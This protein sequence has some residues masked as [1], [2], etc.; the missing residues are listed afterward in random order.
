MALLD[1]AVKK[2]LTAEVAE[3]IEAFDEVVAHDV[4]QAEQLLAQL[5][6][7]AREA[8]VPF[9]G[10]TVTP[11]QNTIPKHDELP[12]PG[13]RALEERIESLIRWNAMAMVHKQNKYDAG[14]GGHIST[15]ASQATLLE[16]GFNHF[17]RASYGSQP[18]DFVYF[19]GHASPGVYSRAFLEGR[20]SEQHLKNFRHELRD[21]PG[22]SSYPHP[23]LMKDFWQFPTVSMGIGPLNAIYQA[24]FMRYLENRGLIEKTDRKIWAFVGD[25]ET[26]E[27]DT[28]GAISLGVREKLD[29]LIFVVNCNLQ[30][31]DGPVR[32]NARIIDELEGD[33]RGTGWNVIKVIWGSDWD[34]LFARDH[35]GLL[36]KRMEECVDGELQA[37]KAKGGAYLRENFFGKYPELLKLVE[38]KTDDQLA[39]L[40]RGGH[41]PLKIFNA[42]KQA[43]EHKGGPTVILAMTVKGYGMAFAQARNPTHSEKKLS[44]KDLEAFAK[45]FDA[46][47][48][49]EQISGAEF[50][51][52]GEKDPALAYMHARR[53]QL[54]GYLPK[55]E[56]K[57]FSFTA[58]KLDFFKEWLNGSKG[59]AASTTMGFVNML[60]G[61]LKPAS[62][63]NKY[64]V[65]IIPDEGRTFGFESVMKSVGIY[66]PEGQKYTPHDA[67]V[68][69]S[70]SEKKDGAILEE[71]ITEAGS[72]AS[73]TAAGTAYTNYNLPIVPFY[74]YYSMFGF[75]RIGDMA[76]AFADS[77]GKGFL[78]G[79]TAGRTTMLGEGLQHQDGHSPVLAGTIPTCRTY[80]PAFL[81]EMAVIIQN[82][83]ERMYEKMEDCFYY[84][85]MYNEDYVQPEVQNLDGIREGILRGIYKYKAAEKP[86]QV[87]LFGSGPIL[88][89]VLEAQQIL[90]E[91]YSIAADVWS[92]TSYNELRRDCLDTERWN[93]LHP[94]AKEKKPYI[95][96][97]LGDA[98]GPIIATSDYMKS[99]P[100]S[101]SPWLGGRLASLGTDGF[102]RS[103]N[104]E[105]LR[106][107]FEVD[108]ESIV[109]ATLSKLVREG[110]VKPKVAE[111]AFAEL[112]LNTEGA[113]SAK[114]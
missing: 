16:V 15:Y 44:D 94:A 78:M 33:F 41:D 102:G 76:W 101:L 52:P 53:S 71:G 111:K 48:S 83:I 24:R 61:L 25:G 105:H 69:L 90:A 21:T 67:D 75:Q 12:Y 32:G 37:F 70:Y 36:L 82:G 4:Q 17:F 65:P 31:L 80:D 81:Y 96:E 5:R 79:G 55:R 20:L 19:Q 38:D 22:L 95:V 114:A 26:D 23:W 45:R 47:L 99:M 109:A 86:A 107:H 57:E 51:N 63:I 56:V 92:V 10:A 46:G 54:G 74:M 43:T 98:A 58:P 112:G 40:N 50:F 73:F 89:E 34:E 103:D 62:G 49:P 64:I 30:R 29:N 28:L 39:A 84:I 88:N 60:N 35:Q 1:E 27:V 3:W 104:R 108:A 66:A 8:G 59:R 14:I 113:G 68:F 93:R 87:Q 97:A 2:D 77:R 18:G 72:M 7:R 110:V 42:Y 13:D 9:T 100:D 106:R 6:T 11:F 91:K 85:T